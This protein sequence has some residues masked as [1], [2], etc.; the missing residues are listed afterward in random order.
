M[1]SLWHREE[2]CSTGLLVGK[3]G[4][5]WCSSQTSTPGQSWRP[6]APGSHCFSCCSN[7]TIELPPS[8]EALNSG[9]S[10]RGRE[11]ASESSLTA[12]FGNGYILMLSFTRNAT[13][14]VQYMSFTYSLSDTQHFPNTRTKG[15]HY[16]DHN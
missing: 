16:V 6:L 2:S 5:N 3:T 13:Q 15:I 10:L 14:C 4:S 11:N 8:A 9:S 1:W 7:S 12:A